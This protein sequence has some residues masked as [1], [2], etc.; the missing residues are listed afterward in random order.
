MV[1]NNRG[2][3]PDAIQWHEGMLLAPQHF[4]Q[5]AVRDS[6]HTIFHAQQASPYHYG[7]TELE[8]DADRLSSGRLFVANVEAIMPDGLCV[9][10][11]ADADAD[12]GELSV[13]LRPHSAE[14][15]EKPGLIY[16]SVVKF[17]DGH[18]M[19]G[20]RARYAGYQANNIADLNSG[21]G[22]LVLPKLR[23]QLSLH[24]GLP[25][26]NYVCMPIARVEV[27][28]ESF[29]L[30]PYE[31][32]RL[33]LNA[34]GPS[35]RAVGTLLSRLRSK[36]QVLDDRQHNLDRAEDFEGATRARRQIELLV[37]SLPQVEAM[38]RSSR[39][40]PF[41][42][43]VQLCSLLGPIAALVPGQVPPD[44]E[45]YSH[46]D[47]WGS[48]NRVLEGLD[49][50]LSRGTQENV[51]EHRFHWDGGAY[52]LRFS[53]DWVNSPLLIS[54]Q[55]RRGVTEQQLAKWM[56][57]ALVGSESHLD[58]MQNRRVLGLEREWITQF[59]DIVPTRDTMLFQLRA[60]PTYLKLNEDLVIKSRDRGTGEDDPV[61][62]S[63]LI[64]YVVKG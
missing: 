26:E 40:H 2:F 8:L 10:Y 35:G 4:Q 53:E 41:N 55:L 39:V 52:R 58:N 50:M 62:P 22:E 45:A 17:I 27:R 6:M 21:Q 36:A 19:V 59:E 38:L 46:D 14:L 44:L 49:A 57:E 7:V 15:G 43:Y 56:E 20:D 13:D 29:A 18:A 11:A 16:L 54:A 64:L 5:Q 42:L 60:V 28:N 34:N 31:P 32:P 48:Y 63:Q 3:P 47:I 37:G 51:D 24:V 23:P 9:R 30:A 33:R 25:P 61:R 1:A 12:F